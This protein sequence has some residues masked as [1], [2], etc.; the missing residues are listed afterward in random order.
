MR[1]RQNYRV[2][3]DAMSS[4]EQQFTNKITDLCIVEDTSGE[5]NKKS[6]VDNSVVH[7]HH[8]GGVKELGSL[9]FPQLYR[10]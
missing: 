2:I 7:Q 1:R 5:S 8:S 4:E 6:S 3:H 9:L 10:S